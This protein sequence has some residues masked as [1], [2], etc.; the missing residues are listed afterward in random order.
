ME[1]LKA[2]TG[3]EHLFL[4]VLAPVVLFALLHFASYSLALLDTLGERR[5]QRISYNS[6]F[7]AYFAWY[8]KCSKAY[9][10]KTNDPIKLKFSGI[11]VYYL[12][13]FSEN[14]ELI[15]SSTF[16]DIELTKASILV[17]TA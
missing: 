4:Q 5:T 2:C 6:I 13:I 15:S 10:E 14:F 17:N 3:E 7:V 11:R 8:S 9:T 12:R 1:E 16:K